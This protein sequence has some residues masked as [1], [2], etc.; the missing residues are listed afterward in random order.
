MDLAKV[1][2]FA[3]RH[4]DSFEKMQIAL[5]LFRGAGPQTVAALS[6]LCELEV[7]EVRKHAEALERSGLLTLDS[8]ETGR[9]GGAGEILQ[10]TPKGEEGAAL[11]D[12]AQ[13]YDDD[14]LLVY[15]LLTNIAMQRIRGMAART[16]ADAFKLR[17]GKDDDDG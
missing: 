11:N 12:L 6:R 4:L 16:F 17:R 8:A 2:K 3:E 10:L 13:L 1:R 7:D 5:A 15:K 14:P 9:M